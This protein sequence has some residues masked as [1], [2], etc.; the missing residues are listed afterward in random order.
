MTLAACLTPNSPVEMQIVEGWNSNLSLMPLWANVKDIRDVDL[1]VQE[2][3]VVVLELDLLGGM[4][5]L[6]SSPE[7]RQVEVPVEPAMTLKHAVAQHNGI[8]HA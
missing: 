7:G 8:T 3:N 1:S 4:V 5:S 6:K 2:S